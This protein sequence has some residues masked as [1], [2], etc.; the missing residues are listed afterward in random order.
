MDL[1]GW[2]KKSTSSPASSVNQVTLDKLGENG[3][4]LT[5]NGVKVDTTSTLSAD[6]SKWANKKWNAIGDSITEH[7]FRSTQ[8][9]HDFIKAKVTGLLVNNYG[10]SG[11][12]WFS[13]SGTGGTNQIFNRIAAMDA[14][15][16]LITV[17]AGT[18]DWA[19]VGK[20]FAM[21]TF[22]DT[23]QTLSFYGAVDFTLK[24][25]IAKYPTK[26]IAVFTP[27][28]RSTSYGS[29]GLN[30][31]GATLQQ[32]ADSIIKVANSLSI[33]VLDLNR[34]GSPLAPW[35]TTNNNTYFNYTFPTGSGDGLHPNDAGHVILA[36]KILSFLNTI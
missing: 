22:G 36:D 16:D 2:V 21:G 35:N 17:F 3:G 31:Q 5:Y 11:T 14:N 12:G 24:Q 32:V 9:Y 30:A 19:S 10:V 13:P 8:N 18:N 7:N 34:N 25:L 15:A 27:L 20:T 23:D 6:A 26:T 1:S 33:P 29:T 4:F 28:A